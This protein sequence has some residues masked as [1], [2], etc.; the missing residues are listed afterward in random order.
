[1]CCWENL[2]TMR[3]MQVMI[4]APA[5]DVA[6]IANISHPQHPQ[7]GRSC[8]H[9][10]IHPQCMHQRWYN[11]MQVLCYLV[12]NSFLLIKQFECKKKTKENDT[13]MKHPQIITYKK[14]R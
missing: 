14:V 8:H 9:K 13:K 2:A 4:V 10:C 3:I 7:R 12:C 6:T 1:M 5:A 11:M